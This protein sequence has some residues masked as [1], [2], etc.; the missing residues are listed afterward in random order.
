LRNFYEFKDETTWNKTIMEMWN[1]YGKLKDA[2]DI[3]KDAF[4]KVGISRWALEN[5]SVPFFNGLVR[6]V[7]TRDDEEECG[8]DDM[9]GGNSAVGQPNA[10]RTKIAKQDDFDDYF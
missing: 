10:K 7:E 1:G 3:L 9:F 8:D 4:D 2:T 6:L 5:G